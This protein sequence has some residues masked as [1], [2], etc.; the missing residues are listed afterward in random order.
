[1]GTNCITR[2]SILIFFFSSPLFANTFFM[3]APYNHCFDDPYYNDVSPPHDKT[4]AI[5]KCF[6]QTAEKLLLDSYEYEQHD[7]SSNRTHITTALHYADSWFR[8]AVQQGNTDA[9]TFLQHT[10]RY[11]I[12]DE[13]K[14]N[15]LHTFPPVS[16][17]SHATTH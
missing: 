17:G 10:E 5:G 15:Q 2:F 14:Y 4:L 7:A 11:L 6:Y 13:Q 9:V 16:E 1:M 8:L 3:P 12:E